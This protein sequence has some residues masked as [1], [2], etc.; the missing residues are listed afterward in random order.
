MHRTSGMPTPRGPGRDSKTDSKHGSTKDAHYKGSERREKSKSSQI[1]E[2]SRIVSTSRTPPSGDR[3]NAQHEE[4]LKLAESEVRI[5]S[6]RPRLKARTHSAPF[7]E[8]HK[9]SESHRDVERVDELPHMGKR[10][11]SCSV[12]E[13]D[14]GAATGAQ[15]ED[16]VAGVVGTARKY[17]PF[18]S[19]EVGAACGL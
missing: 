17:S 13:I 9:S 12:P 5:V 14:A 19:P 15:D 6:E 7:I 18:S 3:R 4:K 11:K 2:T 16:E 8:L 1:Y 10:E